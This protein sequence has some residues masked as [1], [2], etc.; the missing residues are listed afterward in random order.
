M[1]STGTS[2]KLLTLYSS[3][4]KGTLGVTMT[5]P[6]AFQPTEAWP[7]QEDYKRALHESIQQWGEA[8]L[9][10]LYDADETDRPSK[11]AFFE[12]LMEAVPRG[13][14][15][16]ATLIKTLQGAMLESTR[17]WYTDKLGS[18]DKATETRMIQRDFNTLYAIY[19]EKKKS[20]T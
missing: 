15:S 7:L 18:L 12:F 11:E 20:V 14:A 3:A 8:L 1:I 19:A 9:P 16:T 17:S 13:D 6:E 4:W 2:Y 10:V 5:N